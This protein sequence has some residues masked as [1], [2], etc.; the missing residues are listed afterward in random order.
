VD[1]NYQF[2]KTIRLTSAVVPDGSRYYRAEMRV[3]RDPQPSV[4]YLT[5]DA[6]GS[7]FRSRKPSGEGK[8]LV[9]T[10]MP[11]IGDKVGALTVAA[12]ERIDTPAIANVEAL[13][14]ENFSRDD[15]QLPSDKRAEWRG[16]FYARGV[17]QVAE[18]DGS[19]GEC[20]LLKFHLEQPR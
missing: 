15:P 16:R 5:A 13:R 8:Q 11:S 17:G 10:A 20:V 18:A 6:S 9:I 2:D 7:V 19:G 1:G 4:Y 12:T 14:V 3:K